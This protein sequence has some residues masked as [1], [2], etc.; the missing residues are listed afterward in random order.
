MHEFTHE[1]LVTA[2]RIGRRIAE[3]LAAQP[4]G[5]RFPSDLEVIRSLTPASEALSLALAAADDGNIA[6][7]KTLI[8]KH[9]RRRIVPRFFIDRAEIPNAVRELQRHHSEWLEHTA[10]E[11]ESPFAIRVYSGIVNV[12]GPEGWRSLREG[13]GGDILYPVQPH[14]FAFAV[15]L[16][17]A[18]L[19]GIPDGEPLHKLV[20]GWMAASSNSG[21]PLGYRTSLVA[22]YR[23]VALS[24]VSAF[25]CAG[26]YLNVD[27]EFQLLKILLVD[28][29]FIHD[30]IPGTTTNNHLL[31]DGFGL[32]YLGTLYP[33]LQEASAWIRAGQ[34]VWLR[35]LRRQIYADGSGFEHSVHYHELACEMLAAYLVLSQRN[36]LPVPD[37]VR[38]Q[39]RAMLALQASLSGPDANP[40]PL[41]GTTDDPLFPLD[42][43]GSWG[44]AALREVYRKLYAPALSSPPRQHPGRERAFWMLGGRFEP[45]PPLA[46]DPIFMA[47]PDGGYFVFSES[48]DRTRLIFRTGPR[49]G[50]DVAPGHMQA[51]FLSI[52]VILDGTPLI[53]PTGTYTYRRSPEKWPPNTPKWREHFR[54]PQASNGLVIGGYS[55]LIDD[56]GDFPGG[57]TGQMESRVR[58]TR[59]VNGPSLAHVEGEML[60]R[61]IYAGH[62]R[63][64]VHVCGQYWILYDTLSQEIGADQATFHLQLSADTTV[65]LSFQDTDVVGS[66]DT[67][68][69]L[70]R[71]PGLCRLPVISGTTSPPMGWVSPRYGELK[72]ASLLRYSLDRPKEPQAIVLK[73]A[74]KCPTHGKLAMQ[75]VD[76]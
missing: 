47:Y 64:I 70:T 49:E 68:L 13:P 40:L 32:W 69:S 57:V 42:N 65:E 36:S 23:A 18:L 66:R 72:P 5:I 61:T 56:N 59:M 14:R 31:A 44:C 30:S 19:F 2:R 26:P 6:R 8:V 35:E 29:R 1:W 55:P 28:A 10:T 4:N 15:R 33:E 50:V 17:R 48:G 34:D 11:S 43:A 24:W 73:N 67:F 63:G 46:A 22:V 20:A 3:W 7:A 51:D 25:I 12:S 76:G 39:G 58:L 21:R 60:G 41:G 9:F 75:R 38:Q 74:S 52:Y 54:S 16:A 71:T 53:V 37:W 62:R 45:P 27:L